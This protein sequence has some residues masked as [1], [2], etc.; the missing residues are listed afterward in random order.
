M[1][2]ILILCVLGL[3]LT[4]GGLFAKSHSSKHEKSDKKCDCKNP[5]WVTTF[6]ASPNIAAQA[7]EVYPPVNLAD[8]T[9]R[10]IVH[11]SI[12]GKQV[13]V[14]LSNEVGSDTLTIAKTR[15]ARVD[16]GANIIPGTDREVTFSGHPEVTIKVGEVVLSDPISIKVPAESDL[17]ISMYT[18]PTNI[19]DA[20]MHSASL[21][22]SYIGKSNGDF[23]QDVTG[24][25]YDPI[26]VPPLF[27]LWELGSFLYYVTAVEVLPKEQ[28]SCSPAN[29]VVILGDS[30]ADGT[31]TE[32]SAN[33]RLG[34]F[35]AQRLLNNKLPH[36]VATEALGG[37]RVTDPSDLGPGLLSRLNR[38]ALSV[39]GRRHIIVMVG[40]N[41]INNGISPQELINGYLQIITRLKVDPN[42]KVY[43]CTITPFIYS[44]FP[45]NRDIVNNWIRTSGAFDAVFDFDLLLRDP[46][47]PNALA[48][49]YVTTDPIQL[50]PNDLGHQTMANSIDL[51]L[52]REC[53]KKRRYYTTIH[54]I[55]STAATAVGKAAVKKLSKKEAQRI[56][57]EFTRIEP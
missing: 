18:D 32:V 35:L 3:G 46:Q 43:G 28:C 41:D 50:H 23:T 40:E 10:M 15:V 42:V 34:N 22:T 55:P 21:Q 2:R 27:G 19:G 14:R 56:Y 25:N 33:H 37:N 39:T 4:S 8:Q 7:Q 48:P 57:K 13:R 44:G 53:C 12:G 5:T 1:K 52:F 6:S 47:N 49:Q 11:V 29:T 9:V 16:S 36:A 31:S 24:A 54:E 26:I 38:D 45:Q 20:T 17:A 30:I 51:N